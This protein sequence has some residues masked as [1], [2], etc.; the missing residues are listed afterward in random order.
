MEK[1]KFK[2]NRKDKKMGNSWKAKCVEI[3]NDNGWE[4]GD[5]FEVVDGIVVERYLLF[6]IR[7]S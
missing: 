4:I 6:P 5:I 3:L 1:L 7:L 2:A